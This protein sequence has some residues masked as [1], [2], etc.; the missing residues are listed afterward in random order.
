[1]CIATNMLDQTETVCV[2]AGLTAIGAIYLSHKQPSTCSSASCSAGAA[3]LSRGEEG[4]SARA[5]NVGTADTSDALPQDP[6][7]FTSTMSPADD[8]TVSRPNAR[9]A[10]LAQAAMRASVHVNLEPNMGKSVTGVAPLVAGRCPTDFNR[11]PISQTSCTT[12]F[13]MTPAQELALEM[14]GQASA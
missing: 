9:A 4:V 3:P 12:T 11:P 8:L 1:M 2:L 13:N 10:Q 6:G 5:A 14:Q 7:L